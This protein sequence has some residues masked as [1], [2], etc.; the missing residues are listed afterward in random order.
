VPN[1]NEPSVKRFLV[2]QHNRSEFLGSFERLLEDR[3]IGFSYC[4]PFVGDRL[5]ATAI[6]YDAL[7]LLGG[8]AR[9]DDPLLAQ[10]RAQVFRLIGAFRRAK[11]PVIGFGYGALLIAL[12]CGGEIRDSSTWHA[13]FTCPRAHGDSQLADSVDGVPVLTLHRGQ[14]Q[15]PDAV[16][17]LATSAYGDWLIACVDPTTYALLL[18]PEMKPGMLEDLVMEDADALPEHFGD[19]IA[20]TKVH[21]PDM[22]TLSQ[23][24]LAAL[25]GTLD[26]MRERDKPSVIPVRVVKG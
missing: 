18:R 13:S 5:P 20:Q 22:Q 21:W 7:W 2:I 14:V 8:C 24:V 25:V 23:R 15:L 16:K 17:V 12:Q 19:L 10:D 11:R 1:F 9:L 6:Q 4:R 26:L 3:H